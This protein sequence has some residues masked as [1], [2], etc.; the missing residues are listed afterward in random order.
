MSL[1]PIV[2]ATWLQAHHGEVAVADVRWY[3]DGRSGHAAG[4][5]GDIPGAV[6]VDLDRD[7]TA[8]DHPSAGR[9][10]LPSPEH[11]ARSMGALGIGD[12]DLVIAYDD[13][14]GGTAGRLVWMLRAMGHDAALLDGGLAT[15]AGPLATGPPSVRSAVTFAARPW[16]AAALI[17]ADEA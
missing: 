8:H 10:P 7:L 9:H 2:D 16:P 6:F 17:D 15:W 14:G 5:A 11:F 12:D 3:L 4:T 13:S 1:P